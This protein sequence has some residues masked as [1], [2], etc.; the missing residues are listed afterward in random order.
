MKTSVLKVDLCAKGSDEC[1][2]KQH[3]GLVLFRNSTETQV[4]RL[5]PIMI[6]SVPFCTLCFDLAFLNR[7]SKHLS[8]T[9]ASE[10]S[11]SHP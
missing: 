7:L 8:P 9:R 4:S 2:E 1:D 6:Y 10:C 3:S 11:I 5:Q